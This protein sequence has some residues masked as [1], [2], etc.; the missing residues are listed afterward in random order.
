M[1]KKTILSI[2]IVISILISV[3]ICFRYIENDNYLKRGDEL[4]NKIE[5]YRKQYNMLPEDISELGVKESMSDGPYYEKQDSMHY[6][7]FF[8]IGFDESK[9]YS[10]ETKKWGNEP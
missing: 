2:L 3:I 9:V 1:K 4:I 6:V 7:V 8:T 5:L 10:S